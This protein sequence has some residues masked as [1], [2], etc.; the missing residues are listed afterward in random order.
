MNM[1]RPNITGQTRENRLVGPAHAHLTW[2]KPQ[3]N[4]ISR[5]HEVSWLAAEN[6]VQ[7]RTILA[8]AIAIFESAFSAF[9][10]GS[11][12]QTPD[13]PVA[14]EDLRPGMSVDTLG[15]AP[16]TIRWIG[17]MTLFST[18]DPV[19]TPATFLYRIAEGSFGLAPGMPDLMLGTGARILKSASG[20]PNTRLLDVAQI[21]DGSAVIQVRPRS[22][23]QVFHL[24]LESHHLIR[25]N[26]VVMES[27]HPGQDIRSQM[28]DGMFGDFVSLFPHIRTLADFGPLAYRRQN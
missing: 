12:V 2:L 4:P 23:V 19:G 18:T 21:C 16:E 1:P 6:E 22:P 28:P 11:L 13:G 8:P 10:R 17:A 25:V 20:D 3:N 26:N 5:R 9:A 24:A 27:Y 15:G 7:H 14:I